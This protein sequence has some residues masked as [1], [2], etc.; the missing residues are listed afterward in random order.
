MDVVVARVGTVYGPW[1]RNTGVRDTFS[2][3]MQTMRMA[4]QGEEAVLPGPGR[5]DWIYSRDVAGALAAILDRERL[6]YDV[7]NVGPGVEWT[8][9]DWC[10][11]L[12]EIYPGFSYRVAS[13]AENA[14]VNYHL[15]QDRAPF[16]IRRLM[17]DIGFQ[18]R[19]GLG[20]GFRDYIKWVNEFPT[21]WE[22]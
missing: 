2:P 7:Y 21:F 16:A 3:Q 12:M 20:E 18:P 13:K 15:A 5:R 19:F 8:V 10:K 6:H 1:E 9:E 17:E 14:N 4:I 22:R 11:N